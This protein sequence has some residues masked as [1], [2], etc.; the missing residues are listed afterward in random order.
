MQKENTNTPIQK[1]QSVYILMSHHFS[2]KL[3][4]DAFFDSLN[5]FSAEPVFASDSAR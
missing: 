3:L 4:V 2:T 1:V 5:D